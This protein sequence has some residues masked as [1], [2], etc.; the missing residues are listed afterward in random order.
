MTRRLL[1]ATLA[2]T[3]LFAQGKGKGKGKDRAPAAAGGV[4]FSNTDRAGITAWV[5]R[6]PTANL[7]PGLAKLGGALPP[8]LEKQLRRNGR[9]PPG[10][11]KRS[12]SV[13]PPDLLTALPPLPPEYER[14]FIAGHAA[15]IFRNTQ[16]VV[17]IFK[18]F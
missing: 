18:L 4:V 10:L 8:G 15:I 12:W 1:F 16:I 3:H 9:L 2:S 13:F 7:P 6:Q 11:D 17:D 5:R 14:G